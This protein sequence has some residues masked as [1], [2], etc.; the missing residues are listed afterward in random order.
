MRKTH[1]LQQ[2]VTVVLFLLLA[3]A[4][5]F[6]AEWTIMVYLDGD[7]NLEGAGVDDINEMEQVGST[8]DVNVVVQFD[9]IEGYD[10]S[11]GNWSDTRRGRVIADTT[12][13]IVSSLVSVGE[14][15]M[16]DKATVR[17]FVLWAMAQYAAQRYFLVL[18]NHG[19]GWRTRVEQLRAQLG[20]VHEKMLRLGPTP[21]LTQEEAQL[22]KK[23]GEATKAV[24]WD[25]TDGGDALTIAECREALEG[26]S[27]KIDIIGFDACLMAMTEIAYEMKDCGGYMIASQ[28]TEPDDGWPYD[29]VLSALNVFPAMAPEDL[30]ARVVYLYGHSYA[31][32]ETLSAVRLAETAPLALELD[33]LARLL[34]SQT[35]EWGP[36]EEART[37]ARSFYDRDYRDLRAF[38][39]ALAGG[40][41]VD[42]SIGDATQ[43]ALAAFDRAL[44]RNHSG[45]TEGGHGLSIELIGLGGRFPADYTASNLRFVADTRWDELLRELSEHRPPD[46]AYEPNDVAAQA[47][48]VGFGEYPSL[49]L[50][51]DDWYR[52]TVAPD[53]AL[54][55]VISFSHS[56]GDLDLELYRSD[57]TLVDTS[58][59][60]ADL[61]CVYAC[62]GHGG[63]YLVRVYGY[64]GATNR[65]DLS[66][67]TPAADTAYTWHPV[68]ME[69]AEAADGIFLDMGDDDY[70]SIS[71]GFD[72]RFYGIAYSGVK[73]SSNGYLT[74]GYAGDAYN[75][76]P[77]P[78][79]GEPS[80]LIAPFWDDLMP[81]TGNGVYYKLVGAA[82]RRKLVVQWDDVPH[83]ARSST[84]GITFQAILEE[85]TN[86]ITFQYRDVSF[87]DQSFDRGKSATVGIE[88]GDG[89]RGTLYL[90]KQAT[91]TDGTAVSFRPRTASNLLTIQGVSADVASIVLVGTPVTVQITAAGAS[92]PLFYKFWKA[93]GFQT[94]GYGVWQVLR[95][96]STDAAVS[97]VPETD[98]HYLVVGWVSADPSGEE[99]SQAGISVETAGNRAHAVQ[100]TGLTA[101]PNSA[102]AGGLSIVLHTTAIGGNGPLRYL[103]WVGKATDNDWTL[104]R[105]YD[106]AA[107]CTWTPAEPGA[108][109]VLVWVTDDPSAVHYAVA[110][111]RYA[112]GE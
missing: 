90:Y 107:R 67:F 8:A 9:R 10:V 57:L 85:S 14:K 58:D 63:E 30:A 91:L 27:P 82:P 45:P 65:Y 39:E 47:S 112:V 37:A 89:T 79:P 35:T 24:C 68:P 29:A 103:Y 41:G 21:P 88:N 77:I 102:S 48:L 111:I 101:Q 69:W 93:C 32:Q 95:D 81:N 72:F 17:E 94:R 26:V 86:A 42:Q 4:P 33:N 99:Y 70:T 49:H 108:Y 28:N 109:N 34:V 87:S 98:D 75:N 110:G 53:T 84:G 20:A 92:E 105:G 22:S 55:A 44:V 97:W 52:V 7:N 59:S 12:S 2:T 6:S 38:L 19:D 50:E 71:I 100:V 96:W 51:N 43:A 36:I 76:Q 62:A 80:N 23:I 106:S 16:G 60:V 25:D 40:G 64:G 5:A 46:D 74:F 56:V 18:W 61:E 78:V 13:D 54:M 73:I 83:Y 15:N 31:G 1:V 104:V 11:N 66:L 3:A